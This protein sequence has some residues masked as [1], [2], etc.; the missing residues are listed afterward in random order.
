MRCIALFGP[1]PNWQHGKTV[2]EQGLP[3]E[4]HLAA[5]RRRFD[6]GSLLL[7]G[8]FEGGGGIAVL[9][10][11]DEDEARRLLDSDPAVC[12]GVL[13]YELHPLLAYFDAF[14][15]VRTTRSVSE[16]AQRRAEG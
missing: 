3:I 4:G 10:V 11:G 16:L 15:A 9:D 2:Y 1:G 14:S 6:Q 8:P 12:A 7:G 13:G 5:M